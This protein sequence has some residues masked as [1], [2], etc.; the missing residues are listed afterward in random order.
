MQ[1]L[2]I[3]NTYVSIVPNPTGKIAATAKVVIANQLQLTGLR[4][5]EGCNGSFVGYPCDPHSK[6]EEYHDVFFPLTAELRAGI[7]TAVLNEYKK[8][9]ECQE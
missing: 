5:I 1:T 9:K 6:T 4:V 8:A 7:E 2:E 3:T